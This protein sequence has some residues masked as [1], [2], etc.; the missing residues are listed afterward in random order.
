M[1]N[2][3]W[4]VAVVG[5]GTAAF[6]AAVA[7]A[8]AGAERVVLLEKAPE[9][10]FGGNARFSH[11]GFRVVHGGAEEV[12]RFLPD[13][14]P[15]RFRRMVLPPYTV[16]DFRRDLYKLTDG[17]YEREAGDAI[18]EHCNATVQWLTSVGI[19]W[20]PNNAI[21]V[22]GRYYFEPGLVL[23]AAGGTKG[24]L[25]QLQTWLRIATDRGVEVRFTSRVDGLHG[26]GKRVDG[27]RVTGKS[28]AYHVDASAVILA[29]GGFQADAKLRERFFGPNGR[30]MKVRG[31]RHDTG[32]VLQMALSL[33]AMRAGQWDGATTSPVDADAPD[34]EPG[35]AANRYSYQYGITVNTR[36]QRFFD[37]GEA[38]QAYTYATAGDAIIR[39][40]SG[41]AY[42]IFDQQTLP[43]I[44]HYAYRYASPVE[45]S[46]IGELAEGCSIDPGA[47]R[48]T[49]ET[50]N[51]GT[52]P[53]TPFDPTKRDGKST[54]GLRP[55][56]SNWAVPLT[57]PPF[58]AYKVTG[59]IT[60]TFGGLKVDAHARV[61]N[62]DGEPITGLYASG[63]MVGIFHGSY[64]S[65]AG[66]TRN[67]VLSRLAG[68][69]AVG[70]R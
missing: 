22:D 52:D 41:V 37:E 23:Q 56:K 50:F 59:G 19:K 33:G 53:S 38:E 7:A 28:G 66:Q 58:R 62:T 3:H 35:N 13:V 51:R 25:Q 2:E 1:T 47:L 16:E 68:V 17:R 21:E 20:E 54:T 42:Q 63:D 69:D 46:D 34:V 10:E 11:A 64:P 29:S 14:D 6:A 9:A 15:E 12:R 61:L 43:Y 45:A 55:P 57:E 48:E 39:Q 24:G 26:D 32:E 27:L 44:K 67:A 60:F 30:L 4:D 65:G 5:G 31:S 49:V 36:G 18:A 40:P 8:E 70:R